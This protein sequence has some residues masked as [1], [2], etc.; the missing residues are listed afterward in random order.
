MCFLRSKIWKHDWEFRGWFFKTWI[1][2]SQKSWEYRSHSQATRVWWN[3]LPDFDPQV[4]SY[5]RGAIWEISESEQRSRKRHLK[6]K[7]WTQRPAAF[8]NAF[9]YFG[10]R[11]FKNLGFDANL[12]QTPLGPIVVA[13]NVCTNPVVWT[14]YDFRKEYVKCNDGWHS[15]AVKWLQIHI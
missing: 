9:M 6:P 14:Q 8:R 12:F 5:S 4:Y 13:K 11:I 2:D 1:L 3:G 15:S 10:P 7:P